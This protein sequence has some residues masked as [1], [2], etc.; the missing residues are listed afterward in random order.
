VD[1]KSGLITLAMGLAALG[2]VTVRFRSSDR[3]ERLPAAALQLQLL[4]FLSWNALGSQV[5]SPTRLSLVV[6][7]SLLLFV[8]VW[9]EREIC[10]LRVLP[11]YVYALVLLVSGVFSDDQT[12]AV[13]GAFK[14]ALILGSMSV[15]LASLS[16]RVIRRIA[17]EFAIGLT[18]AL[19]IKLLVA[20]AE[21]TSP[22]R[23]LAFDWTLDGWIGLDGPSRVGLLGFS[24]IM[25]GI[26]SREGARLARSA[27]VV[28]GFL[29]VVGSQKRTA[30]LITL[31]AGIAYV[32]QAYKR[33]G[34]FTVVVIITLVVAGLAVQGPARDFLDGEAAQPESQNATT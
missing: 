18:V 19:A 10:V 9:E 15:A 27:S 23:S 24:F 8:H 33:R 20:P 16:Q 5:T 28:T 11:L 32:S 1:L 12:T 34:Y 26:I 30:L 21:T 31:V 13:L 6:L 25:Y 2:W 17:M 7:A 22:I 14:Y 4:L 29:L 3:S